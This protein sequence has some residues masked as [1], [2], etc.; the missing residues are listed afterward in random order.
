MLSI[1]EILGEVMWEV[2]IERNQVLKAI[3]EGFCC[4][5]ASTRINSFSI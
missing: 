3:L 1:D 2:R 4:H 5:S